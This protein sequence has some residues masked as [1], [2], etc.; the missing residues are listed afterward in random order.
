M[1]CPHCNK[2]IPDGA[3]VCPRCGIATWDLRPSKK[4]GSGPWSAFGRKVREAGIRT[5]AALLYAGATPEGRRELEE[6]TGID[7]ESILELINRADLMRIRGVGEGYSDLLDGAGV[8]TVVELA[9]RSPDN[10]FEKLLEVNVEKRLV[11]R[12]PNRKRVARW[13]EQAK[14]LPKIVSH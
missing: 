6:R 10:L 2:N 12:M 4:T 1:K 7:R 14:T 3:T 8:D 13:V 11:R 5:A 9:Q